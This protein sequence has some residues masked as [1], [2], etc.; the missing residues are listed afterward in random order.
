MPTLSGAGWNSFWNFLFQ[1]ESM[2]SLD[3]FECHRYLL[4]NNYYPRGKILSFRLSMT[5]LATRPRENWMSMNGWRTLD[6]SRISYGSWDSWGLDFHCCCVLFFQVFS[7]SSSF[8]SSSTARVL[9]CVFIFAFGSCDGQGGPPSHHLLRQV[10]WSERRLSGFRGDWRVSW[11]QDRS[12]PSTSRARG[13]A[14]CL[15]P[16]QLRSTG[17]VSTGC[18]GGR[19][20][21]RVSTIIVVSSCFFL[22]WVFFWGS[23]Y[24]LICSNFPFLRAEYEDRFRP[25]VESLPCGVA[26]A[27]WW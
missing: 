19:R 6:A 14:S 22:Y 24:S 4:T 9:L 26:I 20:F 8:N 16:V 7:Y 10:R 17:V 27:W 12:L 13:L 15:L 3:W 23:F 1:S 11:Q 2:P 21:C 25:V 18:T 5:L